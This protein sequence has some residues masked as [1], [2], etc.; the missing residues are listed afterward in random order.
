MLAAFSSGPNTAAAYAPGA[1]RI[2]GGRG[3][4]ANVSLVMDIEQQAYDLARTLP[5]S[6]R[7]GLAARLLRSLDEEEDDPSEVRAAWDEE[8]RMRLAELDAGQAET[9]SSDEFLRDYLKPPEQ[10]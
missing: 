2:E 10:P 4:T 9:I 1:C 5:V 7:A 8:I 6:K 3:Q